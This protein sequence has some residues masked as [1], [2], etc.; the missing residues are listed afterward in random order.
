MNF[1]GPRHLL[2]PADEELNAPAC[3]S[4]QAH[5]AC[6]AA[7]MLRSACCHQRGLL[8]CG[9]L[10]F[11]P[12]Q[13][14]RSVQA[15]ASTFVDGLRAALNTPLSLDHTPAGADATSTPGMLLPVLVRLHSLPLAARGF[16]CACPRSA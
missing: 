3:D 16:R 13:Q 15:V 6:H 5:S 12:P 14:P 7:G 11:L 9:H 8:R 2:H 1:P 10:S 4:A